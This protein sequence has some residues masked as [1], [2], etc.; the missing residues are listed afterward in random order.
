MGGS[1]FVLLLEPGGANSAKKL[2]SMCLQSRVLSCVRKY[3]VVVGPRQAPILFS[4]ASPL[5][6][7]RTRRSLPAADSEGAFSDFFLFLEILLVIKANYFIKIRTRHCGDIYLWNYFLEQFCCPPFRYLP[8]P[9]SNEPLVSL[10]G[11]S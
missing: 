6:G 5:L 7:V 1:V 9:Y 2:A 4:P 10:L 8:F 11:R 3:W